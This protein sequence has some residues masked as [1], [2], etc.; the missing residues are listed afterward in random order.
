[1]NLKTTIAMAYTAA[2]AHFRFTPRI[3][4]KMDTILYFET[5]SDVKNQ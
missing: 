2:H 3:G 1:M 4:N 5:K